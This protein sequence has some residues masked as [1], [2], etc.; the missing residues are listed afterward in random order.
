VGSPTWARNLAG[1]SVVLLE[2]A[3]AEAAVGW[4][5]GIWHYC[6]SGV[7]SWYDF[8]LAI[9]RAALAAGL[10][11]R[12][13]ETLAIPTAEFQ[14]AAERPLYSVLDTS[15]IRAEFGIEPPGL[16]ES[17]HACIDDIKERHAHE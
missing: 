17:L 3:I 2:R 9:F 12:M 7:V 5:A 16:Q 11:S 4:P 15:R 13:P 10:L 1:V 14:Q 6:D 8:S